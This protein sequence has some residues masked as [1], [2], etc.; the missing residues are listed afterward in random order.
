[1]RAT[2]QCLHPMISVKIPDR[3]NDIKRHTQGTLMLQHSLLKT[4]SIHILLPEMKPWVWCHLQF[5]RL[6]YCGRILEAG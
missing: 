3:K 6:V 1:M 4:L 5:Q 2:E